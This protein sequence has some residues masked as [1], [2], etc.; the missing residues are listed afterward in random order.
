MATIITSNYF[1]ITVANTT[2]ALA[3]FHI[4]IP[5]IQKS[6]VDLMEIAVTELTTEAIIKVFLPKIEVV[7]GQPGFSLIIKDAHRF[8][9]N[10]ATDF[11]I[12][13]FSDGA[14]YSDGIGVAPAG[15][16]VQLNSGEGVRLYWSASPSSTTPDS[17][18]WGCSAQ[19][20]P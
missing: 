9:S 5:E 1:A 3:E 10:A 19:V 11:F 18:Y 8:I 14:G 4:D 6:K 15:T 7:H 2:A 12:V 13:P 16:S 17:G 20:M